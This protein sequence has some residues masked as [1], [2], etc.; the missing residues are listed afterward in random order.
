MA[1]RPNP[2]LIA[3]LVNPGLAV[4]LQADLDR[5]YGPRG[6]DSAKAHTGG[7]TVELLEAARREGRPVAT[8]VIDQDIGAV[9]SSD[10]IRRARDLHSDVRVVLLIEH[11]GMKSALA[12]MDAGAIDYFF[13]KP[14]A[15]HDDQLFPVLTD[16]L[17]E[18]MRKVEGASRAPRV[19]GT[20]AQRAHPVCEFLAGNDVTYRF[21][22][23]EDDDQAQ[24][25]LGG[26][27]ADT[28]QLPLVVL[29][30]G[31]RLWNP[32]VAELAAGLG[33]RTTPT[34]EE[35]DLIVIGA[36][37]AGLAASVYGASEGLRTLVLERASPGGQA[38]QSSRIENYLG[39]PSGLKGLELAQRALMQVHKFEAE[40]VRPCEVTALACDPTRQMIELGSGLRLACATAL[41]SCGV[42]YRRLEHPSL[43]RLTGRGI[44]YGA[45]AT[46]ARDHEDERVVV[47]GGANSAGQAALHF[48]ERAERV[49][50]VAR[51]QSL[52][53]R[54]SEYLVG[55]IERHERISVRT[56]TLVA[57]ARGDERLEAVALADSQ[58]G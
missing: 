44:F 45:G 57:E 50:L 49:T 16:L 7:E 25:L 30:G 22:F 34:H 51:C 29:E 54:M 40:I 1:S 37:P 39:F 19:V 53:Q 8:L 5:V 41:I 23:V 33:I 3:A 9:G 12:A 56:Q 11:R 55:R 48:A 42:S 20:R 31:R 18:W 27:A 4:G 47:L 6:F 43:E 15:A 14:L 2:L 58:T 52:R 10:V 21:H 13:V 32:S 35:Y 46:D 28:A 36:G 38:G 24:L 17:E 26:V